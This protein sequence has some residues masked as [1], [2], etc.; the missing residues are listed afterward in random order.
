MVNE[1]VL[2]ESMVALTEFCRAQAV[3]IGVIGSEVAAL[4]ETARGLDPAFDEMFARKQEGTSVSEGMS[5]VVPLLDI[6]IQ[7][8]KAQLIC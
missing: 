8:L 6:A 5:K 7:R 3:M 4:R 2:L 1:S